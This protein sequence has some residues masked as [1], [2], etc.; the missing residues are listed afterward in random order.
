MNL[1]TKLANRRLLAKGV[2]PEPG[3]GRGTNRP[4]CRWFGK[5]SCRFSSLL[6]SC[7]IF[8]AANYGRYYS[9]GWNTGLDY[10]TDIFLVF[11]HSMVGFTES[12]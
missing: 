7:C 12:C 5:A 3:K 11:A 6:A 9:V 8:E 4:S 2:D 10:W 1:S